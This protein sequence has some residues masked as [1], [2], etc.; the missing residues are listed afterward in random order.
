MNIKEK[1]A[2]KAQPIENALIRYLKIREPTKLYEAMAH[3]PLAS[4]KRLRPVKSIWR[5]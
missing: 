3:I 1:L 4:G 2:N 5:R